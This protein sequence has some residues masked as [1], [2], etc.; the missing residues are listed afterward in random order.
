MVEGSVAGMDANTR[1]EE[2]RDALFCILGCLGV[3][4][5][6]PIVGVVSDMYR[7]STLAL[8]GVNSLLFPYLIVFGV[9]MGVGSAVFVR[10]GWTRGVY[11]IATGLLLSV[12]GTVLLLVPMEGPG[13]SSVLLRSVSGLLLGFGGAL[14][15]LAWSVRIDSL[16]SSFQLVVFLGVAL[17]SCL[18][19]AFAQY[20]GVNHAL[21]LLVACLAVMSC[22]LYVAAVLSGRDARPASVRLLPGLG[23]AFARIIACFG[24]FGFLFA[25][26]IMQFLIA[27]HGHAPHWTWMLSILGVVVAVVVVGT[28]RAILKDG[29]S[30]LL[31]FRFV[32]IPVL[33]A[34]YP[35]D[36]GSEFSLRFAMAAST[37]ALWI[38]LSLMPGVA[39]DAA[40]MLRLSFPV[41]WGVALGSLSLGAVL[42]AAVAQWVEIA[43]IPSSVSVTALLAMGCAVVA[44]DVVLTRGSLARIYRK[45]VV[46][47]GAKDAE[48]QSSDASITE[49][50][51]AVAEAFGLTGRE[52][53]VLEILARGHGLGRVQ[54]TLYIAEGT[55]I[56]HRR[57]IYQKLGVHSKAELIDMVSTFGDEGIEED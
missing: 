13:A 43:G 10:G 57:H 40:G 50:V 19:A 5:W 18:L 11:G 7:G 26:M 39:C 41:V 14:V 52:A 34:F 3:Q 32:A 23:A 51:Q 20:L 12:L 46:A 38:C 9:V 30:W 36:A 45:A 27:P 16:S 28:S 21:L 42:G 22:G 17:L 54:E 37:F 48:D 55:A 56:T 53:D 33:V 6:L 44:S 49:R 2:V 35:F 31:V 47:T 25:M 8:A 15:A 29:W 1:R 4:T 24:L